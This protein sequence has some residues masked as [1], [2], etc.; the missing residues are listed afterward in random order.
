MLFV[1]IPCLYSQDVIYNVEKENVSLEADIFYYLDESTSLEF[2]DISKPSFFKKFTKS[3]KQRFSFG[4]KSVAVWLKIEVEN[5][6]YSHIKEWFLD[7]GYPSLDSVEFFFKNEKDVFEKRL[8]GDFVVFAQRPIF[9]SS[10]TF[11][12]SFTNNSKQV[13]Y[14]RAVSQTALVFPIKVS[15]RSQHIKN[16][17]YHTM[18]FGIFYGTLLIMLV[19]NFVIYIASRDV[20]YLLY[21]IALIG[22]LCVMSVKNGHGYQY[23]YGTSPYLANYLLPIGVSIW[24]I[25]GILFTKSLI[26]T[27]KY[28]PK[29]DKI[30]SL[31]LVLA[32]IMLSF[33]FF[34]EFRTIG[35][36]MR[37]LS[38]FSIIMLVISGITV[39]VKGNT[40]A[41]FFVFAWTI[42]TIGIITYILNVSGTIPD[43]NIT[44]YA[45]EVCSLL[46]TALLSLALVDKF[47]IIREEKAV[48]QDN[49]I[50]IQEEANKKLEQKVTERTAEINNQ[51]EELSTIADDLS[52]KN[53]A[54]SD[55]INYAKTIQQAILPSGRKIAEA[56]NDEFILYLPKDIVS[57]D[58]YWFAKV[59]N[60]TF[61]VVADCTGHGVPGAF[62]S[63]VGSS[64]LKQIIKEKYI[65]EPKE[66]L[67][68]LNIGFI[69]TLKQKQD[70]NRD[71]MDLCFCLLEEIETYTKLTYA[72][73]KRPLFIYQNKEINEI[74]GTRKSIAGG[75]NEKPFN[76]QEFLLHTGDAIYLSTD[77]YIDQ[78]NEARQRFGTPK[79]KKILQEI[80]PLPMAEQKNI[81]KKSFHEHKQ[82][83]PQRDDIAVIGI[84]I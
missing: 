73:A 34:V 64:L 25:G 63:I 56:F 40:S 79:L 49:A 16:S 60:K 83:A 47:R 29:L 5:K 45:V 32:G 21:V 57:G 8:T 18:L 7:L 2:E 6:D 23:I 68:R 53:K 55:S 27:K 74:K 77:G 43:T 48:A 13:F 3:T 15:N 22:H 78:G 24:L 12:I 72:G 4:Q 59:E 75:Q 42:Y 61:I 67:E 36:I 62:M 54:L 19:Y 84:R 10:Y 20:S 82:S 38:I 80:A 30:L 58:F 44:F 52:D 51:K 50:R 41:R 39:W 81:L 17:Q 71:G 1:S 76:Q 26:E 37:V 31:L 9:A 33:S 65:Y 28:I 69:E 35:M 14:L 66:I 11:P 46:E 70:K